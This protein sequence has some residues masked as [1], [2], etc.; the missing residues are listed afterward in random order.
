MRQNP[1]VPALAALLLAAA[2]AVL[3]QQGPD[4]LWETTMRMEGDGMKM[5]PMTQQV[6]APKGKP[7]SRM[8]MDKDSNC[9]MV[10]SK[11]SGNKFT[12]KMVCTE[13]G[14]SYTGTGEMEDLSKDA[15]RGS[16]TS[17]GVR[18]G[19]KFTMRMDMSG[20]R[21]GNCD[22]AAIERK[23]AAEIA[24]IEKQQRDAMVK[25]CN[26][27][28]AN[29]ATSLVFAPEGRSEAMPC[30]DRQADFCANAGS[31]LKALRDRASWDAAQQKYS[32][33]RLQEAA[34]ACKLDLAATRAPL[35][36]AAMDKREWRW[37]RGN[38]PEAVALRNQHCKGRTYSSVEPRY[39]DMCAELGGL[40]YTAAPADP[41][42]AQA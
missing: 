21:V 33:G 31:V 34:R 30:R 9:K 5:P 14:D 35:C 23:A 41:A 37:L 10:E 2:S 6:C 18:E 17:S 16:F 15:Y 8:E 29:L 36:K 32:E 7:E 25:V 13:G 38:C 22:A 1:F 27:A 39:S 11:Q 42:K 20:K 12:F 4:D 3:A 40:S 19:R 24:A 28:V 26:D